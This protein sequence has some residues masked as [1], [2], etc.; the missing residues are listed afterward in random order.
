MISASDAK[1][2]EWLNE[3]CQEAKGDVLLLNQLSR[4]N[5][6]F[7]YYFNNVYTLKSITPQMFSE[8]DGMIAARRWHAEYTEAEE[9]KV[10]EAARDAQIADLQAELSGLSTMFKSF[11]ESQKPADPAPVKKNGKGKAAKDEADEEEAE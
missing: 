9:R 5:S 8:S 10:A 4:V 7:S 1:V 11:M 2:F 6:V 3:L